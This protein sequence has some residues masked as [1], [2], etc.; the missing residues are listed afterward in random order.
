MQKDF[1]LINCNVNFELGR[2]GAIDS[3]FLP[4]N[5]SEVKAVIKNNMVEYYI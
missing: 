2:F 1:F 4:K 5:V 3:S